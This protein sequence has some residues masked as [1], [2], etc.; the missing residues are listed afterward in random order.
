MTTK[1]S[2]TI[3]TFALAS[4]AL[5]LGGCGRPAG[6]IFDPA[7]ATHRWPPPPDEA[8]VRYVGALA[9]DADLKPGASGLS[10]IGESLFGKEDVN[11]FL[12]PIAVCTDGDSRVFIVDSNAQTVHVC[13]LKTR[14]YERWAPPKEAPPFSQPVAAAWD[15]TGR[16]LVSDSVGG[17]IVVF[18]PTGGY[19]GSMGEGILKRPCGIAIDA[20]GG[21]EPARIYVADS[22]AHQVV[23]LTPD[24]TESARFG[25]RGIAPGEFNFP[26]NV[27]VDRRGRVFVSDSLNFRVQV[28]TSEFEPV[29]QIGR[30]G[31]MPGYFSQPKGIAVDGRDRLYVVDANFE[32]VQMFDVGD[33]RTELLMTFGREGH[34]PGEFWL[35]GGIH[36]DGGGQ[37]WVADLYNRRVQVFA[38]IDEDGAGAGAGAGPT[39]GQ[40]GR[41]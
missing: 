40:G 37:I 21:A 5:C 8:R 2:I 32:A 25:T 34:G 36:I 29:A 27:A 10:A 12:S 19:V 22:A 26:T 1:R 15:A 16:L 41:P 4:L 13:D 28:F 6:V 39:D 23:V 18:G 9:S 17:K 30:K 7:N 35:P 20:R 33:D 31:D 11:T 14:Q 38:P 3:G 24:G